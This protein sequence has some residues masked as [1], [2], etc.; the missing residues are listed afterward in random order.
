MGADVRS[1]TFA[2][3]PGESSYATVKSC[4]DADCSG[5]TSSGLMKATA[6]MPASAPDQVDDLNLEDLN[7]YEKKVADW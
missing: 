5:V 4:A 3:S 1:Y 7:E 6:V 2:L